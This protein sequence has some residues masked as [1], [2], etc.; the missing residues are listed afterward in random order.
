MTSPQEDI[1]QALL[2]LSAI[3]SVRHVLEGV[4]ASVSVARY[5]QEDTSHRIHVLNVTQI[6]RL[7][8]EG[9]LQTA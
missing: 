5:H 1:C 3:Q 7:A 2:V 6:A 9:V 4:Q 8:L